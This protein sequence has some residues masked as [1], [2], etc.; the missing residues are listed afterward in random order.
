MANDL[1]LALHYAHAFV[2]PSTGTPNPVVHRDINPRNVM[3]TYTGG[4]K[5]IDFGI[6]K[7][8]GRINQTSAGFVKGTL[9]YMAPEQVTA[10]DIDGRADLFAT[11][12]ILFELLSGRTLF[13]APSPAA[14]MSKV[15]HDPIPDLGELV[16]GL[17]GDLVDAVMKGLQRDRAQRW[18]TG[19]EYA[20]ALDRAI[21]D[22]FDEQQMAEVMASLFEDKIGV[23]R[24]LLSSSDNASP[25]NLKL[26]T[27][28]DEESAPALGGDADPPP[29]AVARVGRKPTSE[30]KAQEPKPQDQTQDLPMVPRKLTPPTTPR[31]ATSELAAQPRKTGSELPSQPRKVTTE[32]P[33]RKP[34]AEQLAA[35]E[36]TEMNL[37][38]IKGPP[39]AKPPPPATE[40]PFDEDGDKTVAGVAPLSGK[41]KTKSQPNLEPEPQTDPTTVGKKKSNDTILYVVLGVL[42]LVLLVGAI[43]LFQSDSTDDTRPIDPETAGP[44]QKKRK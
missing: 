44:P 29:T 5:I 14:V 4:T 26:M 30:L 40:N 2:E 3:I 8:R 12:V 23:T 39:P 1:L 11:S 36:R 33:V 31:R 28:G 17:P 21:N 10:K 25:T 9:Q 38:P 41:R 16:P 22:S 43:L 37:E 27:M 20:R 7:A 24:E 32:L 34:T 18:Q 19:R 15:M 13:D 42:A 6:A 35:N